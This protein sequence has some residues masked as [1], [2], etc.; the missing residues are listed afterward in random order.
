MAI[1]VGDSHRP[2]WWK[3]PIVVV[4]VLFWRR[5]RDEFYP[6]QVSSLVCDPEAR[7]SVFVRLAAQDWLLLF[8]LLT[9]ACEVLFG[10]GPKRTVALSCIGL[11]LAVFVAVI[12]RVRRSSTRL[13]FAAALLYRIG[14]LVALLGSF[15]E[16]QW[17]LP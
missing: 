4:L 13:G 17:I 5:Q 12:W 16:L 1:C 11:D 14:V 7:K 10:H 6:D 2:S 3:W 15:F 8:Y 9:L